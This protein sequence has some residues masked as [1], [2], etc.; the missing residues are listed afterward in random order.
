MNNRNQLGDLLAHYARKPAQ[1][2]LQIDGFTACQRDS[3]LCGDALH[4]DALSPG[5]TH[6]LMSTPGRHLPVRVLIHEDA[7]IEDVRRLLTKV[8][9]SLDSSFERLRESDERNL[10]ERAGIVEPF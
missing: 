1:R 6:E 4:G 9:D 10:F 2:F 8:L 7:Q 3:V 5:V